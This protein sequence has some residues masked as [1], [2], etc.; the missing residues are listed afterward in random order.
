MP[1]RAKKRT[2]TFV[3]APIAFLAIAA[4]AVVIASL[5]IG[6]RN[7]DTLALERQRATIDSALQQYGRSL[8]R[9]LKV[10]TSW[11]EAYQRTRAND[12]DWMHMFYGV[13]LHSL[14]DYDR[15]F[16]LS[17]S[18]KPVYAFADGKYLNPS[19]FE[20][21]ARDLTDLIAAE[22]NPEAM[23]AK[24]D[25]VTKTIPISPDQTIE[26]RSVADVRR[27]L[28]TPAMAVVA[29]IVPDRPTA[30]RLDKPPYLLIAIKELDPAYITGLGNSFEFRDL[31]W[32][33]GKLPEDTSTEL[34]KSLNGADVGTLGWKTN[35][36][37]WQFVREAAFG[38]AV[39]LLLIGALTAL[40]LKWGRTQAKNL[41]ESEEEARQA[42]RTDA[43]TGLPNRIALS[44]Q[45]PTLIGQATSS[46][47]TLGVLFIDIE[48][49][50][51]INDDFGHAAGDA[52]LLGAAE[53]LSSL[54]G[55]GAVLARLGED[56]FEILLPGI[57]PHGLAAIA[58]QIVV[59]LAEPFTIEGGTRVYIT[60]SVGYALAP[61]DGDSSDEIS[62]RVGLALI[63]AK[64]QGGGVAVAFAPHMDLELIRRRMLE[65]AL[66]TAV[67]NGAI[68]VVYQPI[69]NA[70]GQ[71]VIAVE[72][73]A[74]WTDPTMGPISP[75]TFIP[76][77][78]ETGLITRIG[79]LVLRR[80]VSDSLQWPGIEVAV[81]VSGAQIHHGDIV[82]VV[83]EVLSDTRLPPERLGIEVTESILLADE[84]R[85]DEQI[86]RL[87]QQG[88]KVALDDFGTGYS[89]LLYL[90]KFGFDK[91]KIDR[92]YIMEI[93]RSRDS[94]VIL[95]SII[96]LGLDLDMTITAEGVETQAQLAWLR[97][98]GCHQVQGYLLSPP[99]SAEQ[100]SKFFAAHRPIAATG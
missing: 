77:A 11:T 90:R 35:H 25:V 22:R 61:G 23:P 50:R 19:T 52:V 18:D 78:E 68:D 51:E 67:D 42:A 62:R 96:R 85:A 31:R 3:T 70:A 43:L 88:V 65:S 29:T 46:S 80:A 66:R 36:P 1:N 6:A 56:D 74:R 28:G 12:R 9:E 71:H 40:L 39:A 92:S 95:T 27:I 48:K 2:T 79:E 69:M 93:G 76:L 59:A 47:S 34:I 15:V 4:I 26:H 58:D 75:A 63:N 86:K 100:M 99:L 94:M 21:I 98:S 91:L 14:L 30:T 44:E 24:Y 10:Q 82:N 17:S 60:A 8:A 64:S 54:L 57:D 32:V 73:L 83:C 53:R 33:H 41:V 5:I 37:G 89:S 16:V 84:K 13:Y 87:Q 97:E 55:P 81:N 72:A 49:F 45:F 20:L 38:L 7:T